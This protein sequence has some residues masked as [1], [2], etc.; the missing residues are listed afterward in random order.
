MTSDHPG[1]LTDADIV[2]LLNAIDA[3]EEARHVAR[4]EQIGFDVTTPKA[5][6]AIRKNQEFLS[7]WR[8][9]STRA[10]VIGMM[11]LLTALLGGVGK[12]FW[13]GATSW[14]S[15]LARVKGGG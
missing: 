14:L 4:M 5:R 15:A 9:G 6:E 11:M 10:Q 1:I 8:S 2:R 7:N 13:D 12:I 3:A